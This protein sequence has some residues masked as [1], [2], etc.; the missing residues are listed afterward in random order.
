MEEKN[1]ENNSDDEDIPKGALVSPTVD[2]D[3][4]NVTGIYSLNEDS[5]EKQ[6]DANVNSDD[7][8]FVI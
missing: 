1:E 8:E 3:K 2:T 7:E 6:D 4:S 5:D